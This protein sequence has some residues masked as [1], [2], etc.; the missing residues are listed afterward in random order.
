M[1][2]AVALAYDKEMPDILIIDTSKLDSNSDCDTEVHAAIM[3]AKSDKSE[4]A[5]VG[6]DSI[7][8]FSRSAIVKDFPC[9]ISKAILL[10]VE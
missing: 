5:V 10:F 2:Y 9:L 8:N 3:K 6:H 7:K 4:S 1:I